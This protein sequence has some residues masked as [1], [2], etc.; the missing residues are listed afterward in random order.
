MRNIV[1][2]CLDTVR[3]DYFDEYAPRLRERADLEFSQCRA[4]SSWSVPS[5]A[6]MFTGEL[7]HRH[8]IHTHNRDF[9]ELAREDTFLADLPDHRAVGA[10]ANVWAG[11]SFGFDALF[12]SFSD[13]SPDRRFPAGIDV[14]QFG[15]RCDATGV[16]RHAAF[17]REALDHE[18]PA[19][20]LANGAFVQID[21]WLS[22]LPVPNPFDDGAAI[23]AREARSQVDDGPEPFFLFA[24]FMD[25]H[26]PLHHVRGYDRSL[27]DAPLSWTSEDVDFGTAVEADD[28]EQIER[29]TDLYGASIDYLDRQ[30]CD[31]I[32]WLDANTDRETTVVVTA[33]H[34]DNMGTAVDGG[35]W[36]HVESTLTEGLLHVPLLVVNAPE[37]FDA[38]DESRYVSH[39]SLPELLVGLANGEVPDVTADRIAAER[40]GH[41][42]RLSDIDDHRDTEADSLVRAVYE[43]D[44]KHLW[45]SGDDRTVFRLDPERACWEEPTQDSFD[46][47]R[48]AEMFDV[49]AGEYKD[50]AAAGD[51]EMD[52]D[53]TI[54]DRLADL[55]YLS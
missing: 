28:R 9:S 26:G 37:E 41:S 49:P 44:R 18:H 27:H 19:A 10:S 46:P 36:G 6:S 5:H 29:Y 33:D 47:D 38:V 3:K 43:D 17:V 34:G 21:D 53:G 50:R 22:R 31:L 55:G 8:G 45:G 24:N 52:V 4:A 7:P 35:R 1:L 51:E 42:G 12:D 39:C 13:V 40:I 16:R 15:Q 20:S 32:D 11:T 2:L 14:G 54:Q 48:F 30:V 23:I 25:A